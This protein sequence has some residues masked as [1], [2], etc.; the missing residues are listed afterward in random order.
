LITKHAFT[1]EAFFVIIMWGIS[2]WPRP[3]C[4]VCGSTIYMDAFCILLLL[5]L[6]HCFLLQKTICNWYYS[7]KRIAILIGLIHQR[8]KNIRRCCYFWRI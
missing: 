3:N 8:Y 4:A 2:Y 5:D 6:G 7:K 1:A